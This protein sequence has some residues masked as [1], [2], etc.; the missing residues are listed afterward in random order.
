MK[1]GGKTQTG[2]RC[3]AISNINC[4][5]EYEIDP[6]KKTCELKV[7]SRLRPGHLSKTLTKLDMSTFDIDEQLSMMR[8]KIKADW[9]SAQEKEKPEIKK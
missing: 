1:F 6:K 9:N 2:I 5:V 7:W 3:I 8:L 4:F